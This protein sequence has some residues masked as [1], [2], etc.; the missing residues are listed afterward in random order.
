MIR[1]ALVA[2]VA[3]LALAGCGDDRIEDM[4]TVDPSPRAE[5]TGFQVRPALDQ[6]AGA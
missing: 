2:T 4:P 3:V 1:P 6:H 5:G